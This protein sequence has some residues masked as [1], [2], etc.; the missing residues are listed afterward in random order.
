MYAEA[1][2]PMGRVDDLTQIEAKSLDL[3]YRIEIDPESGRLLD[4]AL[5]L[6]G[7]EIPLEAGRVFLVEFAGDSVEWK[8]IHADFRDE[9]PVP[10]SEKVLRRM[11]QNYLWELKKLYPA[12]RD[13]L[14]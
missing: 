6:N 14:K 9:P 12:V 13:F 5:I 10:H 8:Q 4:E 7:R 3:Q 11:A 1:K 2:G